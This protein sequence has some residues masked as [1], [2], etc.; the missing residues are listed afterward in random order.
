MLAHQFKH[1]I[2]FLH[3]FQPKA[4][5]KKDYR[6]FIDWTTP[7]SEKDSEIAP[8]PGLVRDM[9]TL[10]ALFLRGGGLPPHKLDSAQ[11]QHKIIMID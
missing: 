9:H 10:W 3:Q 4:G 6:R 11:S 8:I 5:L 1:D 2:N 7:N